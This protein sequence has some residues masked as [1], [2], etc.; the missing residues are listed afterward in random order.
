MSG[1]RAA[2][3]AVAARA[4]EKGLPQVGVLDSDA[5]RSLHAGYYVVFS[6]V[7]GTQAAAASA[8]GQA[9]AAGFGAA[10]PR[11]ISG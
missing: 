2:A 11:E 10:Y 1:G 6:G 3:A 9:R 7:Y 8:L 5:H 4:A